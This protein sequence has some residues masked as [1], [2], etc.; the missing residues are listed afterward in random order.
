MLAS[1]LQRLPRRRVCGYEVAVAADARA[2]LLGLAG[3][4]RER[5]G[6]GLLIPNCAGV[7]TFGMR[8]DL[9]VAFLDARGEP[10]EL[11]RRLAPCRLVWCRAAAA[12]LELPAW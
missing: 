5:V 12:T 9:D 1:R 7:H 6:E 4:R 2:R 8:F 10:L 3:L 11:H